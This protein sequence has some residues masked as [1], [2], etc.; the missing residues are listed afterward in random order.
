M[1]KAKQGILGGF[2]GKIGTVIGSFWKGKFIMKSLPQNTS[3]SNSQYLLRQRQIF[4][5][6]SQF[7]YSIK[8]Q[9]EIGW[10]KKAKGMTAINA[11]MSYTLK[12]CFDLDDQ[13]DYT[14]VLIAK[15]SLQLPADI[16]N[17]KKENNT[18]QFIWDFNTMPE[19]CEN[20]QACAT[21]Y[22][23][24]LKSM[25]SSAELAEEETINLEIPKHWTGNVHGWLYI[26]EPEIKFNELTGREIHIPAKKRKL[27]DSFYCGSIALPLSPGTGG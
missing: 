7:L 27:S 21:I 17:I 2:K 8:P 10:A 20:Y 1:G 14:K 12:N 18:I 9:I 11:A 24:A 4:A 25:I 5:K 19:N 23:P 13:I 22:C 15:G 26:I 3:K 16:E 6:A